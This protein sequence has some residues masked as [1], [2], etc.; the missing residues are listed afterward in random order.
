MK[1]PVPTLLVTGAAAAGLALAG[2]ATAN[3][4]CTPAT[5]TAGSTVTCTYSGGGST[6]LTVPPGTS[7][8]GVGLAG[9][10]G[11][12]GDYDMG[13]TGGNGG[14]GA[15]VEAFV[16]A[17]GLSAITVLLGRGGAASS[18]GGGFS[19]LYA[20][21]AVNNASVRV[22][23]GG[24]GGGAVLSVGPRTG[25]SGAAA[26]TAAG[27]SA[28]DN[29]AVDGRLGGLGGAGGIGAAAV[30]GLC[31]GSTLPGSDWS[32]GGAGAASFGSGGAGGAGYGGGG[33]GC[34][35]GGGAGGSFA[36]TAP[37]E[38][39]TFSPTGG[40]G[41]AGG[42]PTWLLGGTGGDGTVQITF[43]VASYALTYVGNGATGGSVPAD[44]GTN[45]IYDTAVTL[46]GN[47]GGL[48][49]P[50]YTFAGWNT[51]AD[52]SG[53]AYAPGAT[54]TMRAALTLYAQ[55]SPIP[56]ASTAASGTGTA[57]A[58]TGPARPNALPG[59]FSL[60]KGAGTTTG[61][62][63][64]GA[65]RI[66]QTATTGGGGATESFVEMAKAKTATGT[67]R[68]TTNR[69]KRTRKVTTR[70]YRCSIILSKGTWA[71]T[72]TAR[73]SAGVVAEGNRRVV[74]K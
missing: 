42:T 27:G 46:D 71:I 45:W 34:G 60:K 48:A 58:P 47:T 13:E 67:C 5:P 57:P 72:T 3:P 14:H 61:T 66:T 17:T 4:V 54:V 43:V 19:A 63:P 21:S 20:G 68:I 40:A 65:T 18:A 39:A 28:P 24:G 33:G 2:Q 23:A 16:D 50:G 69:N 30:N 56:A 22:V 44:S 74:V 11:A 55:W 12:G 73:G 51:Q 37:D 32:A 62:V 53:T 10:G 29:S 26:G 38:P 31:A 59:S 7:T 6:T 8:L 41:G 15:R 35:S 1:P 64:A 36:A 49:R 52:G 9:G 70:T 25:G